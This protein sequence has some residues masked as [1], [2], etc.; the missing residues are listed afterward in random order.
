MTFPLYRKTIKK[1]PTYDFRTLDDFLEVL[2]RLNPPLDSEDR[3]QMFFDHY[4]DGGDYPYIDERMIRVTLND[5]SGSDGP[6]EILGIMIPDEMIDTHNFDFKFLPT[7][8]VRSPYVLC[9]MK[10]PSRDLR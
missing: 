5:M 3:P 9:D 2:R 8:K 1:F 7:T 10:D 4:I 6:H